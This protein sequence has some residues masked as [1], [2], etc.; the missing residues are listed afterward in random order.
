MPEA[1]SQATLHEPDEMLRAVLDLLPDGFLLAERNSGKLLLVNRSLR[2][3][4]G[5]DIAAIRNL[6]LQDIVAGEDRERLCDEPSNAAGGCAA[7]DNVGFHGAGGA[8][9]H[10]AVLVAHFT[11]ASCDCIAMMLHRDAVRELAADAALR[12]PELARQILDNLP[13]VVFWKDLNSNFLGCNASA[14]KIAGLASPADIVGKSDFDMPWTRE[15]SEAYRRDDRKVME[16]GKARLNIEETQHQADGSDVY[17]LT[18]KVPLRDVAG[19]VFGI[20]GIFSDIT[21][22]KRMELAMHESEAR[23][24]ALFEK[25]KVPMLLIDPQDGAIVEAN[26]AASNYYGYDRATLERMRIAEINIFS[27]QQVQQEMQHARQEKRSH[28]YFQHRL[29]DGE[30]RD[31]EVHSG[32]FTIKGR[33]LLYSVIHDITDRREAE[34]RLQDSEMRFRH[35]MEHAPLGIG[36]TDLEGRFTQVN[37]ALCDIV[38]SSREELEGRLIN[39][40]THPEDRAVTPRQMRN[41]VKGEDSVAKYEKRYLHREGRLVWVQISATLERD[42]SGAP[43]YYIHLVEDISRRKEAEQRVIFLAH[44]D[45][46]TELPNRELFSDRLS[47][48]ISHARRKKQHMV[49]F[50]I[51]LDGFKAVNDNYGHQAGDDVLKTV[52]KR[53]LASVREADTVARLGG[54]EF[55]IIF[56]EI[57]E[58]ESMAEMARKIIR[59]VSRPVALKNDR[60]CSVGA[61]I[62]ISSYPGNGIEIDSLMSAA[63]DAMYASK[64]RGRNNFSFYSG[65]QG[66]HGDSRPWITIDAAHMVGEPKLDRQHQVLVDML[67]QLNDAVRKN[68]S[69]NDVSRRFDEMIGYTEAHFAEEERMMD[70]CDYPGAAEHKEEHR[71]LL[72]EAHYLRERLAQGGELLVLQSIKDWLLAHTENVD[73]PFTAYLRKHCDEQQP[74]DA[75]R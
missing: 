50:F 40:M 49:L 30:I 8:V 61:S 6:Q 25:S 12:Q 57:D 63:D 73:K 5:R 52:A 64:R 43:L 67:N 21:E 9:F 51:D 68:E 23:Y 60:Q 29:A 28:F 41:L 22:R 54:D 15:Q 69:A 48:S 55:A 2:K 27:P 20:L 42:W 4:L 75:G 17:I 44:H 7:F 46:L 3:R 26:L 53:M 10:A 37:Q 72:A 38:G 36:I 47:R 18:S 58:P 31:V 16:S 13:N 33:S 32:P 62:G 39:D 66:S 56:D 24:R 59:E 19:K 74:Q 14:A 70:K 45:R 35:I 65:P 1:K 34:R 71:R 11:A